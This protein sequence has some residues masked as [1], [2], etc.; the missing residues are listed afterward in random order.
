MGDTLAE[1]KVSCT[2][3][4]C[5]HTITLPCKTCSSRLERDTL[6]DQRARLVA[7][8]KRMTDWCDAVDS[9]GMPMPGLGFDRHNARAIIAEIK[10]EE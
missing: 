9:P 2:R 8:L 4:N 3:C 6:K 1:I 10:E 7:Q 5:D